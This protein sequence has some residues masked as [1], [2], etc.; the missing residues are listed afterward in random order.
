MKTRTAFTLIELLVVIAIIGILIALLLPAVQAARESARRTQ[1]KNQLKQ[2]GLALQ[3]YHDRTRA[4]PAAY[5]SQLDGNGDEL[6]P[7]WGWAATLLADLEQTNLQARIN[8]N[9]GIADPKNAA[10][11]TMSLPTFVCP[12]ETHRQEF[13]VSGTQAAVAYGNYV[14]INGNGGVSDFAGTNDGAFLRN[15]W[16]KMAEISDGL[17]NTLFVGE[18]CSRMSFTTWT[19]AVTGGTVP[20]QLDPG[21][22]EE[23]AALVLSHAGPHVPNNPEVTDA[24]A[25][26]S[27]HPMG[28]NFLFGDGSVHVINNTIAIAVYD[29]LATRQGGEA[30]SGGDY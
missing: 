25:T 4:F 23:A 21:A 29:A 9:L 6:G 19:G 17:S 15:R 11:R 3:N 24:D 30:T 14:A 12:S 20:A 28:V 16:L 1:C 5:R 7:S 13:T 8:Y 27:Y 26:A 2:I 10:T 18:R 22:S